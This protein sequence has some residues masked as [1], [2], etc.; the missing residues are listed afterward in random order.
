MHQ[1]LLREQQLRLRRVEDDGLS[2]H[3]HNPAAR[4]AHATTHRA[5]CSRCNAAHAAAAAVGLLLLLLLLLPA[6][7][8]VGLLPLLRHLL[9]AAVLPTC[10]LPLRLR[11]CL[12]LLVALLLL[13]RLPLL[14]ALL[15]LAAAAVAL[16]VACP[17]HCHFV[18]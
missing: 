1:A 10:S 5:P 8:A 12:L 13:R 4:H 7:A 18:G 3:G 14:L 6:A 2:S 11:P 15:L 17:F 9:W 16:L